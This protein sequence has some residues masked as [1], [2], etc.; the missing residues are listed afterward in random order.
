MGKIRNALKTCGYPNWAL[1]EGQHQVE[2]KKIKDRGQDQE[3]KKPKGYVV[4]PYVKG[5]SERL[6]RVFKKNDINLYHKAG[7]TLRQ[8]L[9]HPKDKLEKQEQCGV[10]YEIDCNVCG[11]AYIGETGRSLSERVEEHQKSIEKCDSKSA[12]SQ[13]QES[14][15]HVVST[16]PLMDSINILEKETREPHRKVLEAMNIR[17]RGAKLNRND[18]ADL[19][20]LYLPLLRE[21]GRA[22]GDH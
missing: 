17:L 5:V 11:E 20:E 12:L 19:P 6:K 4:L 1:K 2:K 14:S 3:K 16:T 15:G 9:V 18:G 22:G 13:H 21:E 10:V 7:T 8:L